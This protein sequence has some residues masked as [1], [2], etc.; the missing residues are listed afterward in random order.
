MNW[1]WRLSDEEYVERIRR[2]M[3]GSRTNSIAVSV[4]MIVAAL[5]MVA[6]VINFD[7][8]MIMK[9]GPQAPA[10]A[11]GLATTT[12]FFMGVLLGAF[13]FE[14]L[15]FAWKAVFVV[16]RCQRLVVKYFDAMQQLAASI[17]KEAGEPGG[18]AF[19]LN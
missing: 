7:A 10:G 6:F 16:F 8:R 17:Q 13:I 2:N 11:V 18:Q 3:S 9:L 14:A 12:G 5:V 19:N 1:P 15:N 4:V